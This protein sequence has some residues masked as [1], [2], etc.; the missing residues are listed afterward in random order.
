[1]KGYFC[2][3]GDKWGYTISNG[4]D[5]VTGKRKRITKGGFKTKHEAQ[6]SAAMLIK[7]LDYNRY[8]NEE[9]HLMER[10]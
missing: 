8:A 9:N 1:M 4:T 5:P 10:G 7:R 6:H 2:K 3:R